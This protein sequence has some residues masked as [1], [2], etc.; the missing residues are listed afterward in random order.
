MFFSSAVWMSPL[1]SVQRVECSFYSSC[2]C[3]A[4]CNFMNEFSLPSQHPAAQVDS[5]RS[6]TV[7]RLNYLVW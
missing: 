1:L 5:L 6:L 2:N 4:L 3:M 7:T